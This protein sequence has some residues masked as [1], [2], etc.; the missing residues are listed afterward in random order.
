MSQ[1]FYQQ[2]EAIGDSLPPVESWDPHLSGE[3]DCV[4][5]RN[6]SWW[7]DG[8]ELENARLLRLF[9]TLLKREKN[10]Y[11]L[12]T[13][14]EKWLIQVEDL[15]F[16]VIELDVTDKGKNKQ[17]IQL[18]TNVGDSI[19]IDNEHQIDT[20]PISGLPEKQLIPY[21]HVRSRLMARFNRSTYL[22][23]AELLKATSIPNQYSLRCSDINYTL[24]F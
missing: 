4:I 16:M 20:S 2:I 7:L 21:V 19:T 17:T 14:V 13:P 5:K 10:N 1:D 24:H 11:Y 23:I 6:G 18:R 8:S 15:P 22:E 9:S 12:V 3:M